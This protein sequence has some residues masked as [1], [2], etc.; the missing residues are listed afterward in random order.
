MREDGKATFRFP[1]ISSWRGL[2][3]P[4]GGGSRQ[5]LH[6]RPPLQPGGKGKGERPPTEVLENYCIS[7]TQKA[8]EGKTWTISWPGGR[9]PAHHPDPQPPAEEQPCLIGEPGVGK[10]AIAEGL[11]QYHQPAVVPLSSWRRSILDLTALVAGTPV[12]R[13][14][15]RASMKGLIEE[16]KGAGQHHPGHRRGPQ[17]R[18][19]GDAEGSMNAA[20]ILKPALSGARSRSSATTLTEY[21][22]HIE[23]D[24]AWSAASSPSS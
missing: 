3:P 12:P 6:G 19:V 11:A 23:K 7:L 13:L 17:H 18:G 22:K 24:T 21:R 2:Q 15:D 20:N 5:P 1:S 16:I 8:A 9:D 10:A 4:L 14:P